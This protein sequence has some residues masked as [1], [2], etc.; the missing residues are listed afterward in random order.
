MMTAQ[1]HKSIETLTDGSFYWVSDPR[2]TEWTVMKFTRAKTP[3]IE[4]GALRAY[5]Q[6]IDESQFAECQIVGPIDNPFQAKVSEE[7]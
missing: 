2:R 6:V 7:I 5:M 4:R 3:R 1:I